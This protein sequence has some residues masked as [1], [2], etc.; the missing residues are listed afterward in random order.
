MSFSNSNLSSNQYFITHF[1]S[2]CE[3]TVGETILRILHSAQ[4]D[5]EAMRKEE[6]NLK[7]PDGKDVLF[8]CA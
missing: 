2:D 5:I 4:Y 8:Y 7:P 1:F 3:G 6:R